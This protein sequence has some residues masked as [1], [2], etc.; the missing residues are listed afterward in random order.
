MVKIM[1]QFANQ[2]HL[3]FFKDTLSKIKKPTGGFSKE[4]QNKLLCWVCLC[5]CHVTNEDLR[6]EMAYL[7]ARKICDQ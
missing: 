7:A 1:D 3:S 4:E 5:A 6:I 2:L